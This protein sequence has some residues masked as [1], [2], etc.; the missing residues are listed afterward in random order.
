MKLFVIVFS[1]L[2]TSTAFSATFNCYEKIGGIVQDLY[3]KKFEIRGTDKKFELWSVENVKIGRIKKKVIG[4]GEESSV[5]FMNR[6]N[7]NL[8][9]FGDIVE[10]VDTEY[11]RLILMGGKWQGGYDQEFFCDQDIMDIM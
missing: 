10:T 5:C 4:T 8:C 9:W 11:G 2:I 6:R 7:L 3:V 1:F